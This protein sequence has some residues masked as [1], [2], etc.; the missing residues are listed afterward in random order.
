MTP[1]AKIA[2]INS[3][4]LKITGGG[5][6]YENAPVLEFIGCGRADL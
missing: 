5:P 6:S 4:N 2:H 3:L 1:V